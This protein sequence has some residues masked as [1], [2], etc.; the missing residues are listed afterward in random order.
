[1]SELKWDLSFY[2]YNWNEK[3]FH[4]FLMLASWNYVK[5]IVKKYSYEY[6]LYTYMQFHIVMF[7]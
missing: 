6:V 7:L 3:L 1:M 4:K 5:Y 2:K